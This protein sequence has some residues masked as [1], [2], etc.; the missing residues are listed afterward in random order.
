MSVL[1]PIITVLIIYGIVYLIRNMNKDKLLDKN[2][3]QTISFDLKDGIEDC[4]QKIQNYAN[5]SEY[6]IDAIDENNYSI[7]LGESITLMT[8]GFYFPIF[9]TMLDENNTRI[10][11][12]IK[13]KSFQ[14][15]PVVDK[16]H[17]SFVNEFE[18]FLDKNS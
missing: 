6:T 10:E 5:S 14:V 4:F 8:N 16:R 3:Q 7:V 11:V 12:G 15:G 1:L 18:L 2:S 13:S 9:L 17:N